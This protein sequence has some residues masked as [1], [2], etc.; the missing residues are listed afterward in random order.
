MKKILAIFIALIICNCAFAKEK[1]SSNVPKNTYVYAKFHTDWYAK[2]VK[3]D[4]PVIAR[5]TEPFVIRGKEL[6]PK[7]SFL[8]GNVSAI[9]KS[10]LIWKCGQLTINFYEIYLP[11]KDEAIQLECFDTNL[12]LPLSTLMDRGVVSMGNLPLGYFNNQELTKMIKSDSLF[13]ED[14]EVLIEE[15]KEI[16]VKVKNY[17]YDFDF[18]DR[19]W[20]MAHVQ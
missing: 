2:D 8:K 15:D 16:K 19:I 1:Y 6:A 4:Q 20:R 14:Y 11:D 18:T 12:K 3:L 13:L 17:L 10:P 9:S 7:G 5:L